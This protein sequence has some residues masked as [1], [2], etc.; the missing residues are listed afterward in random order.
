MENI[1]ALFG[2][3][4]Q[5]N[6]ILTRKQKKDAIFVFATMILCSVME[7]LGVSVIYPLL[8]LMMNENSLKMQW[9]TRWIYQIFPEATFSFTLVIICAFVVLIYLIKNALTL[10]CRYT[11]F[12]YAAAFQR[13]LSTTMLNSFLKRPYEYFLNTNSAMLLQHIHGDTSATY[14][15]LLSLFEFIAEALTVILIGA[16]LLYTDLGVAIAALMLAALC[17]LGIVISFK[18]RLKK[19]GRDMVTAA[20]EQSQTSFQAIYGIKEI[21]VMD[22]RESFVK[23]YDAASKEVEKITVLYNFL[24][25]CPDRILEGV[26]VGGFIGIACLRLLTGAN[27]V[28]FV[29]VLGAFAM[30]AFKILPSISKMSSRIN[31]IVFGQTRLSKTYNNLKEVKDSENELNKL[32]LENGHDYSENNFSVFMNEIELKDVTWKYSDTDSPVLENVCMRIQKG[33]AVA[34]IG[35]SGAGKTTLADIILG[36]FKP[37][38]GGVYMD[39][40]NIV[41]IPH[42]WCKTVGYVPQTVFLIDDTVRANIAFGLPKSSIDD[43]KIWNALEQAQLAEFI[44]GLPNGLN[45]VVGER[46]IKFSGGQRQRVAIA[47]ALY[48]NPEV[49][50][51]DEATSALDTE[52]ET[53]VMESIDALLGSKTIIIIAHRLSTIRSCDKVFEVK[54]GGIIE[55]DKNGIIASEQMG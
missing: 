42:I 28:S 23:Q 6:Y 2:I 29:P 41:R 25:V 17:F 31:S 55:R 52:T 21:T 48:E 37:Q 1:K 49:L 53:A 54:N 40:I 26:C 44:R 12:K 3:I 46:G 51:L 22:R 10:F 13:E 36:L 8:Q 35:A 39:G 5:L 15:V 7:L 33:E 11:Q 47:R 9:Y 38:N 34:L 43:D 32:L 20:A 45:T 14:N 18:K 19:A 50:V 30:G 27:P 16:Y 24:S 4:Y